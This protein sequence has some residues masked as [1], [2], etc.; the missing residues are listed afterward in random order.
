MQFS[1]EHGAFGVVFEES[2][3][4][5]QKTSMQGR[6]SVYITGAGDGGTIDF[7]WR[8]WV[9]RKGEAVFDKLLPH[10]GLSFRERNI[11]EIKKRKKMEPEN[12]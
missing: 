12:L 7:F 5:I 1:E 3:N 6:S 9:Q 11:L 10:S 2:E 8:F 4:E